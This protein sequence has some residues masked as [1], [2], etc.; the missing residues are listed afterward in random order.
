MAEWFFMS[1]PLGERCGPILDGDGPFDVAVNQA[2]QVLEHS[3]RRRA[4]FAGRETGANLV[5]ALVN[6]DPKKALVAISSDASEQE[7]FANL[8]RGIMQFY[9]NPTHHDI[10]FISREEALAVG[11][12]I[13]QLLRRFDFDPDELEA[14]AEE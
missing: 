11:L 7:G 14:W 8:C 6:N 10:R 9:R 5:S 3:L 1:Q 12:L 2:T 4:N 13:D